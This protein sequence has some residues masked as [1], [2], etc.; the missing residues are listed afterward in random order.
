[1]LFPELYNNHLVVLAQIKNV[2]K[3]LLQMVPTSPD[4]FLKMQIWRDAGNMAE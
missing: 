3:V 1:M 4:S 2:G